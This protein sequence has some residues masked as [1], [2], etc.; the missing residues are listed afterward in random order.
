MVPLFLAG[1]AT[2]DEHRR[3]SD[4][5]D[6]FSNNAPLG[7]VIAQG[8]DAII[9]MVCQCCSENPYPVWG[10]MKI[11]IACL[12]IAMHRKYQAD[13]RHFCSHPLLII[14]K[15]HTELEAGMDVG[16]HDFSH[17]EELIELGY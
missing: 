4:H 5:D 6:G 3:L 1:P 15:P 8:A 7:K 11:I 16:L 12:S 14:M 13:L 9:C 17:T 10:W 2:A